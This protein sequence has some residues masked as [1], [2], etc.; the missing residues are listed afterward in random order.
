MSIRKR[1]WA[2]P[3]ISTVIF[4]VGVGFITTLT[5][6]AYTS[7]QNTGLV[8]YPAMQQSTYISDEIQGITDDF[9]NAV[10]EGDKKILENVAQRVAGLEKKIIEF[11]K[12]PGKE[13]EGKRIAKEL[14]TY[15]TPA[16]EAA[17]IMLGEPGDPQKV[18][19]EMQ[20]SLKTLQADVAKIEA[21][22]QQKFKS[23]ITGSAD[24]VKL[25]QTTAILCA[26]FVLLT[27]ATSAHF[28]I[29]SIWMQLGGEPEYARKIASAVAEGDLTMK[30]AVGPGDSSSLLAAISL[31]KERLEQLIGN[32][33]IT[34][35]T[36]KT[37]SIEIS[38]GNSDLSSRTELQAQNLE[39]TTRSIK[40]LAKTVHANDTNAANA[41]KMAAESSAVAT[42]GGVVVGDVI[43]TMQG[44]SDSAKKIADIISV[45]DGIAFQTNILALNAA[46]EAARAGE[47]G[48]GFAVVASEVRSLAQRSASAAKEIKDLIN[49]SLQKVDKG[50][51]MVNQAG[52]T[53]QE[54]VGSINRVSSIMQEITAA[55]KEQ[56]SSVE[57]VASSMIEMDEMTQQNAALVEEAAAAAKSMEQQAED[58]Y[59]ALTVFK[60]PS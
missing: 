60:L 35:E 18:V 48:R 9:K 30:I 42:K 13:V 7:I 1:I 12:L 49:D 31:M 5:S 29:R 56:S 40:D 36:I 21:A 39:G 2:L 46:V 27:L 16:T 32:I 47:Q 34:S 14:A 11:G 52:V 38:T 45:I 41:S 19:A 20:S 44:I 17:K 54:I 55:S 51:S 15:I 3:A 10:A 37:G 4:V 28:I 6:N 26:L 33:K 23:G 53:M 57:A 24:D 43:T 8:D 58:L 50:S 22:S 59:Q 25:I